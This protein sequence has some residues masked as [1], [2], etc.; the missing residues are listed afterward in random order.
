MG[1]GEDA[2]D[3]RGHC[4]EFIDDGRLVAVAEHVRTWLFGDVKAETPITQLED[5]D[6]ATTAKVD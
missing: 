4:V 2:R 1:H 5:V 3:L 6:S